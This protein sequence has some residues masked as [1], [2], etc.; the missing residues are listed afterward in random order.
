MQ[1]DSTC[2]MHR[3]LTAPL[4]VAGETDL[5]AAGPGWSADWAIN[6]PA[7]G[8]AAPRR[9]HPPRPTPRPTPPPALTIWEQ[10]G[11]RRQR[12]FNEILD[13]IPMKAVEKIDRP[14]GNHN[15]VRSHMMRIDRQK[16]GPNSDG[17]WNVQV[18][19]NENAIY[20]PFK[21]PDS[22]AAANVFDS[23]IAQIITSEDP[24]LLR[25]ALDISVRTSTYNP[26]DRRPVPRSIEVRFPI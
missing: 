19:L 8:V 5:G 4:D 12:A 15:L 20:P 18:Q 1:N 10:L 22:I 16:S 13:M 9:P 14:R 25:S 11:P 7:A 3:N 2:V 21:G 26:H 17:S 6:E 24:S 23:A